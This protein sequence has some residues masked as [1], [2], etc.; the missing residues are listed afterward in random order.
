M[1]VD[2]K[3]QLSLWTVLFTTCSDIY[4]CVFK[5][6]GG[7]P[8]ALICACREHRCLVLALV[9]VMDEQTLEPFQWGLFG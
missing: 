4:A 1:R 8:V 2:T 5:K 3:W 6:Y 9:V 7:V